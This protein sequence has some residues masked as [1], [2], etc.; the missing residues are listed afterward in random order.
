MADEFLFGA[1]V[2]VKTS[3]VAPLVPVQWPTAAPTIPQSGWM[4]PACGSAHAPWIATC[5]GAK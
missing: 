4:C 3:A 5:P 1:P 2:P